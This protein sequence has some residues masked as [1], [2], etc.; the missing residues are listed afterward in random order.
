MANVLSILSVL[1]R[2]LSMIID[3]NMKRSIRVNNRTDIQ[4]MKEWMCMVSPCGVGSAVT[5]GFWGVYIKSK[6][7]VTVIDVSWQIRES[8]SGVVVNCG[9]RSVN[10][11]IVVSGCDRK[12]V[13][14]IS[15]A[16]ECWSSVF[17]AL[18][19]PSFAL[20]ES[21]PGV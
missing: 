8:M 16:C 3:I 4:Y 19:F 7:D 18:E 12:L 2:F 20:S 6:W 11:F 15:L 9:G 10:M 14:F 21:V 5:V 13:L 1:C 17:S